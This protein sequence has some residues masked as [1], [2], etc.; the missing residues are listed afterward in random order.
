MSQ[1]ELGDFCLDCHWEAF[2]DVPGK[3]S[4]DQWTCHDEHHAP[5]TSCGMEDPCCKVD[6][7]SLN[8]SS[9][10]DGFVDCD[11]ST[12]CSESHCD[13]VNCGNTGPICFDKNCFSDAQSVDQSIADFLAEDATLSW[14]TSAFLPTS[15]EQNN[16]PQPSDAQTQFPN[17]S[18]EQTPDAQ[19]AFSPPI[20]HINNHPSHNAC[21]GF[22]KDTVGLWS[23]AYSSNT[24]LTNVD[25]Y[26]MLGAAPGFNNVH[27]GHAIQN[28]PP[29]GGSFE[30]LPCF[31][32]N[33][34]PSCS[35]AGYQHLGC[36][37]RNSGDTGLH[38][39]SRAQS[40]GRVHRHVHNH[41][42]HRVSHYAR[43][44]RCSDSSHLLSSP[45]ETPPPLDGGASSILTS[46]TTALA[47]DDE[48][49]CRWTLDRGGMKSVCGA[50]FADAS[51]LQQHL[52][53]EHMVPIDGA[54][55]Y[56]YYCRWEGC[57]RPDEPFSQKSK[58]QGHF[59]T[60]SNYKSFKCSVCG[61]P[62]ARQATLERHE[63]SHRGEKPYK[64]KEC[65]KAFTD[66][67]ELKT[68]SRTHTGEKPFKCT[69]PGCNFQTGDSSNMSSHKLTHG[70][71]K[72]KCNFPGCSKSFTRPDQLKRHQKT[73][74]KLNSPAV[75]SSS[76]SSSSPTIDQFPFPPSVETAS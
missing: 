41:A 43:H 9:V 69:F 66:S 56:G 32:G 29:N 72:H 63:R 8:C 53:S 18:V 6:N 60:H 45:V 5:S 71:R 64:C 1:R 19:F 33:G 3:M 39:F 34:A 11:N 15:G 26:D 2:D 14:D 10:C 47:D 46:P 65:G 59:L 24:D 17:S 57:H 42:Q 70:E 68:H 58:L 22:S 4:F 30:K 13:D 12:V 35:D 37:L 51:G 28:Q 50:F 62:F 40:Q 25:M 52:V 48:H 23:P 55:G 44:S 61:K 20:R 76:S 27:Q 38:Q 49:V 31:L 36:Y 21:H 16:N 75:S 7:C 73:T 74:H 54:K 67:S